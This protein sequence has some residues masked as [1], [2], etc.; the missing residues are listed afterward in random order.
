[1]AKY[2]FKFGRINENGGI[3]YAPVP[4]EK[5]GVKI[6]TNQPEYYLEAG[7]FPVMRTDP[8][9]KEGLVFVPYW[10]EENGKCIQKWEE[11]EPVLDEAEEYAVAAK[12]LL[13][14]VTE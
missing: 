8:P 12:I 4:I 5:D 9:E 14:E 3:E 13:G 10:E 6:W 2:N 1:M 11:R 7:Y